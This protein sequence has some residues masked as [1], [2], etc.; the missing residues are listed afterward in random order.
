[1]KRAGAEIDPD[2]V[3]EGFL[4]QSAD[5]R[6]RASDTL[7]RWQKNDPSSLAMALASRVARGTISE[8]VEAQ[9]LAAVLLRKV[10]SQIP[11]V[12]AAADQEGTTW[13]CDGLGD[14][15]LEGLASSLSD[16]SLRRKAA[17]VVATAALVQ[18]SLGRAWPQLVARLSA[19]CVAGSCERSAVL[20]VLEHIGDDAESEPTTDSSSA[21]ASGSPQTWFC[22][23]LASLE[24]QDGALHKLL[25][26]AF[27]YG[28][29][30]VS[31]GAA[32]RVYLLCT[33]GPDVPEQL[34]LA[35]CNLAPTLG[36][37]VVQ[38]RT[39]LE[40]CL[41]AV[42]LAARADPSAWAGTAATG[43]PTALAQAVMNNA[44]EPLARSAAMAALLELLP[45]L[46]ADCGLNSIF[47]E[48]T[49]GE[50][51]A[52]ITA[53]TAGLLAELPHEEATS[54]WAEGVD[55]EEI[56]P[57]S[58]D[59]EGDPFGELLDAALDSAE[60]L[61]ARGGPA[62]MG[63]RAAAQ[64]L[65]Q[66]EAW[67]ARHGGLLLL[68]RLAA[69]PES[70]SNAEAPVESC[71]SVAAEAALAHLGHV[72][73]RVRWAAL[74]VWARLLSMGLLMPTNLSEFALDALLG[75]ASKEPYLRVR[76]RGLLV[77]LLVAS[78]V[79]ARLESRADLIF[80]EVLIPQAESK[81]DDV[82]LACSDIA[83]ALQKATE[84]RPELW[85]QFQ[86]AHQRGAACDADMHEL[87]KAAEIEWP[88]DWR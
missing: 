72:H 22:A 28:Q 36:E 74:E 41:Q 64:Q 21:W 6:R 57:A 48:E 24:D 80:G 15:L 30:D 40:A 29:D 68:L 7:Q 51:L 33:T 42:A 82:R 8:A 4:S 45:A 60:R 5:V 12:L 14:L 43:L 49:V 66:G 1:M 39:P 27:L 70:I 23:L 17:D 85:G 86:E 88:P 11:L 54:T 61:A 76:R 31:L 55:G 75:L 38:C 78:L 79:P 69:V 44:A 53:S 59:C 2:T 10:F 71:A 67:Q 37:A 81:E 56:Q 35:V 83:K 63:I 50:L 20:H 62:A 9:A 25:S 84:G 3:L 77:L 58:T 13:C 32:A 65:L 19:W 52:H 46:D 26:S 47:D 18:F 87:Q 34:R 16:A 73:P